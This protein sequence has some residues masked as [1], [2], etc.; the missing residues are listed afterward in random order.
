MTLYT[1]FMRKTDEKFMSLKTPGIV[2][3]E[4]NTQLKPEMTGSGPADKN[5]L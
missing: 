4:I 1:P 2:V 3:F 5:M